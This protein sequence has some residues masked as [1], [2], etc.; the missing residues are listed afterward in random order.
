[1]P[2]RSG[3]EG[4]HIPWRRGR[5]VALVVHVGGG[6]HPGRGRRFG[7]RWRRDGGAQF[8]DGEGL[9]GVGLE[10]DG[11]PR[12]VGGRNLP[13]AVRLV[14]LA[15]GQRPQVVQVLV[16]C[17]IPVALVV[18]QAGAARHHV[19][20][21]GDCGQHLRA[22]ASHR[23]Q[24]HGQHG[25]VKRL[26]PQLKPAAGLCPRPGEGVGTGEQP[27]Q[28]SVRS[29]EGA[30]TWTHSTLLLYTFACADDGSRTATVWGHGTR[31][32]ETRATA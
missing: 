22:V 20:V 14:G 19:Q 21:K 28:S 32:Q 2:P 24:D 27:S 15:D 12:V 5:H 8:C 30:A 25:A 4:D 1:M 6:L 23:G 3:A 17:V 18:E 29:G 10:R 9:A 26:L 7:R 11:R 13:R 16:V 31:G